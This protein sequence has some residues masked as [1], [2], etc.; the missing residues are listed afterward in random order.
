MLFCGYGDRVETVFGG[1]SYGGVFRK[2]LAGWDINFVLVSRPESAQGFVFV[3]KRWDVEP[4][5]RRGRLAWK[6]YFRP[7]V[8]DYKYTLSSSVR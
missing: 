6:N 4:V 2:A 7:I 1:G 5:R 8:K 3:S